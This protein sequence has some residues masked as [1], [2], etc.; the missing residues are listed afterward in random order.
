MLNSIKTRVISNFL[1]A[2]KT[3]SDPSFKDTRYIVSLPFSYFLPLRT[4]LLARR[5]TQPNAAGYKVVGIRLARG[6]HIKLRFYAGVIVKIKARKPSYKSGMHFRSFLS[7][8]R[9]L[10]WS[11]SSPVSSFPSP[12]FLIRHLRSPRARTN[13]AL[14]L[15]LR[16]LLPST[17]SLTR[18]TS[19]AIVDG[20]I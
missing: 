13:L 15:W 20:K 4:S 7:P 11:S 17:L 18:F 14:Q 2:N 10:N 1:S 16:S 5:R 3:G 19:L 9:C 8:A 12:C 6:L